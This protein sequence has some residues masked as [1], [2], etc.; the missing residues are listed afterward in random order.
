MAEVEVMKIVTGRAGEMFAIKPRRLVGD[1]NYGVAAMLG[2]P[3][4]EKGIIPHLPLWDKSEHHDDTYS[5]S[6]FL[7]EAENNRYVCPAGKY[8]QPPQRG[9]AKT[10]F[11]YRASVNDCRACELK[12]KCCP[13]MVARKID[14][15]PQEPAREIARAIGKT[16]AYRQSRRERRKWRRPLLISN[17]SSNSANYVAWTKPR[18]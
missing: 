16:E 17:A 4:D 6:V 14:R 15:S 8:L 9:Q 3:I 7:F 18:P 12:P 1:T 2:W 13:D 10:L 11:L 5:C